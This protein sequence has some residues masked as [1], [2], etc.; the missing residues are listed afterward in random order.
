VKIKHIV[1][2]FIAVLFVS[3]TLFLGACGGGGGEATPNA[4]ITG[5][6]LGTT[7][8]AVDAGTNAVVSSITADPSTKTFSLQ[9]PIGRNYKFYLIENEGTTFERSY[10]VYVF[11]QGQKQNVFALSQANTIDLGFVDTASGAAVPELGLAQMESLG[12]SPVSFDS[13]VPSSLDGTFF[14]SADMAGVWNIHGIADTRA[15]FHTTMTIS[16]SNGAVNWGSPVSNNAGFQTALSGRTTMSLIMMPGGVMNSPGDDNFNAFMGSSRLL[17]VATDLFP[18]SPPPSVHQMFIAQKAPTRSDFS[19][20][21]LCDNS[22]CT[23][24]VQGIINGPSFN[25][26]MQ[27]HVTFDTQGNIVISGTKITRND[28]SDFP[29]SGQA[30]VSQYTGQIT[31]TPDIHA[32]LSSFHGTI[33]D[34]A[35]EIVATLNDGLSPS[36]ACLL[37]LQKSTNTGHTNADFGGTWYMHNIGVVTGSGGGRAD[38]GA[39]NFV[40]LG[41]DSTANATM[42][43][44][45]TNPDFTTTPSSLLTFNMT[46]NG[47]GFMT[48]MSGFPGMVS[49]AMVNGV[50]PAGMTEAGFSGF[51]NTDNSLFITNM[52]NTQGGNNWDMMILQK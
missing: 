30:Q 15:W 28:R 6:V 39:A 49:G 33:N 40:Y 24:E 48:G 3:L 12:M 23:W 4:T 32:Y 10:P 45:S 36:D 47:Q 18:S 16:S 17:F 52:T 22:G 7:V 46:L 20:T 25:G 14:T 5:T 29:F 42:E 11:N 51:M 35:N 37:V 41:S 26:W 2:R 43:R 8:M 34:D 19:T 1:P 31:I 13:T 44:F 21:D 9:L 38:F 50:I 27:G